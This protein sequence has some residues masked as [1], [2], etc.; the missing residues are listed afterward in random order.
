LEG[1]S[2]NEEAITRSVKS[3][4][5]NPMKF[6]V[7]KV[8]FILIRLSKIREVILLL[9]TRFLYIQEHEKEENKLAEESNIPI[10]KDFDK[11]REKENE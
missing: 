11:Y 5:M 1:V 7:E 8:V 10:I 6:D 3:L 9:C 4:L 2:K